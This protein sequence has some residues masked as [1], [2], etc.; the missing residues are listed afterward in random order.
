MRSS[1]FQFTAIPKPS[2]NNLSKPLLASWL[3][4]FFLSC[5]ANKDNISGTWKFYNAD[6]CEKNF[7]GLT[8][9]SDPYYR[10][11]HKIYISDSLFYNPFA[12]SGDFDF[13]PFELNYTLKSYF[14]LISNS[15][16][17][18]YLATDTTLILKQDKCQLFFRKESAV[19]T[20]SRKN[21]SKIYLLINDTNRYPIDSLIIDRS[22]LSIITTSNPE[23][24]SSANK[25]EYVTHLFRLADSIHVSDLNR[26]FD[27]GMSDSY[28]YILRFQSES[29]VLFEI[30][31]LGK[32]NTP[33]EVK[34][35][36]SYLYKAI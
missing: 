8:P 27:Q 26:Q 4:L 36:L 6:D 19:E 1:C 28:E 15:Q 17:L 20:L 5:Q 12:S 35:L 33:F 13:L 16:K 24:T 2:S 21:I 3:F 7:L 18:E 31:T 25:P 10:F 11:G 14:I 9:Y 23:K 29:G 22:R 34:T 32:Y 30:I